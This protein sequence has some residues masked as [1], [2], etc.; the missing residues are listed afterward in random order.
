MKLAIKDGYSNALSS[1][2]D[3]NVTTLLVAII[4]K[5]FGTG[6]IE[7]FATTLIIGIFT[8]VFTAVV[9]TRLIFER[10]LTRNKSYSFSTPMTKNAFT[11]VNI[12][13]I[14][15]RKKF[16]LV[17]GVLVLGAIIAISTRGLKPSVEFS[18]GSTFET[19]FDKPV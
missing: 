5:T 12:Q 9:V 7:S 10:Q 6:P 4:L 8:S 19:V 15:N 17:S 16:Y 2:V 14:K 18:G 1:I 13:F 11:N 3:A